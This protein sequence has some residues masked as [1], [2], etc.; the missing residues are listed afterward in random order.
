MA[1]VELVQDKATKDPFPI[2]LQMGKA[3]CQAA[4]RRGALLRPLG[5][6]IVLMPPLAMDLQLLD[7]LCDIVYQSIQ[8]V[9]ASPAG[10]A[11]TSLQ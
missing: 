1:G 3:V 10:T 9:C 7:E 8:E 4:R 11:S 6:V 5:N 2:A